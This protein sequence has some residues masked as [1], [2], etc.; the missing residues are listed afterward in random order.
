MLKPWINNKAINFI[1]NYIS[2]KNNDII[3]LEFGSGNS[4]IYF[5][6]ICKKV[7]SIEHNIEWYDKI[8]NK[9]KKTNYLYKKINYVSRP[10]IDNKF[11]N[12]EKLNELFLDIC[13]NYL[14]II[15]IDGIDRV[16][17]FFGSINFLKKNGIVILDD[18][19]RIDNPCSDGSYKP[20]QDYCLKNNF[21][22]YKFRSNNRNTDIWIK[23]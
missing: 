4:T 16:N 11:Y 3:L 8:K 23:V 20:I 14:D 17:C 15:F 21:T 18:S 22:H 10:R 6:K 12:V 2:N 9:L 19:N 5:E 13:D 1:E 7:Y